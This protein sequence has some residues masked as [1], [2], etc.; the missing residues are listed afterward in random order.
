M[1]YKSTISLFAIMSLIIAFAVSCQKEKKEESELPNYSDEP[2]YEDLRGIELGRVIF[3]DK[4][5]SVNNTMSCATCHKQSLAFSDGK[6]TSDGFGGKETN[7]NSMAIQN[8]S[9]SFFNPFAPPGSRATSLFWDGRETDLSIMVLRPF[10]NHVEMGVPSMDYLVE[11]MKD[12]EYYPPLFNDYFGT[13]EISTQTISNA[14]SRFVSRMVSLDSKFDRGDFTPQE[15]VGRELFFTKYPCDDC[16]SLSVP[17]GYYGGNDTVTTRFSN[18][19]LN[20]HNG[21]EGRMLV[22][23]NANDAGKFKV[24][25]LRNVALTAPYMHDG[26]VKTLGDVIDHYSVNIQPSPTLDKRLQDEN[27]HPMKM[28]ITDTEKEAL[29]AFLNTLTDFDFITN[30]YLSDPFE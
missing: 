30:P 27:G 9:S 19:G 18:I 11:K 12:I 21:D 16:H 4:K 1:K 2:T 7:R 26:S 22:T 24:P 5:L 17:T 14:L 29:V 23:G 25:S 13:D 3:Y 8:L 10:V 20:N 6:A 15:L 28:N